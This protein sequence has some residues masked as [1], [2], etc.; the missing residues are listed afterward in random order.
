M[1]IRILK[2]ASAATVAGLFLS[3]ASASAG[4]LAQ[5]ALNACGADAARFCSGVFPGGG[6]IAQCLADHRD[7]L[8][9]PCRTMMQQAQD[10]RFVIY[11]CSADASRLCGG[12]LPGG[13]RI[14]A[15]LRA[16]SAE[17]SPACRDG[18]NRVSATIER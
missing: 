1:M 4:P 13:G 14:V 6:R 3:P 18:L 16:N 12:I 8:S 9:P 15:C 17:V 7:G 2:F 10:A 11:A 5:A